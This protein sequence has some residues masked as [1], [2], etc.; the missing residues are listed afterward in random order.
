MYR[1]MKAAC[2]LLV[3]LIAAGQVA[4]AVAQDWEKVELQSTELA[5]GIWMLYGA[6]GNHLLA[7]GPDGALLVDADYSE[8]S[9]KLLAL[10]RELT[11]EGLLRVIVDCHHQLLE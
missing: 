2:F 5:P 8:M 6:G 1:I 9:G 3:T 4:Q 11:G 7:A 10:V